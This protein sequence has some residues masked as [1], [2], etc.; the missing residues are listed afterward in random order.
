M[1]EVKNLSACYGSQTVFE[2][3]SFTLPNGNFTALC[4]KN[5]S[6]KSTLLSLMAGIVPGNLKFEGDVL[7]DGESV[8]KMNRKDIAQKISFL[9]QNE[10]PVWNMSVGQF[11]ETGL[12]SA[13]SIPKVQSEKMIKEVLEKIGIADFEEKKIFNISGGEFQKCRLARC[14]IQKSEYMFFDEPSE[15]LDLPF[16]KEF[17]IQIKSLEKTILFSIHDINTAAIYAENFI[18][19]S[20][21]KIVTGKREEVFTEENISKVFNTK[22]K[23]FNHPV[24]NIPQ[25]LFL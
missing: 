7:I 16:Q 2:N 23:V 3:L 1:I 11:V 22:V 24:L 25:V 5:G 12:Y 10:Q 14:L 18:L 6:G 21:G 8:F 20:E 4:G 17:L 19:L 15:S 13:G 9:I